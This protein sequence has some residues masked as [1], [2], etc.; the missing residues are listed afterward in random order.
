MGRAANA[1]RFLPAFARARSQEGDEDGGWPMVSINTEVPTCGSKGAAISNHVVRTM[2]EYTGRGPT[3]HA[4]TSTRTPSSS[5]CRTPSPKASTAWWP[6]TRSSRPE[7]AQGLPGHDGPG[8]HRWRRGDP[9]PQG[10]RVHERQPHR[11]RMS[12]WRCSCSHLPASSTAMVPA[13][14]QRRRPKRWPALNS[15]PVAEPSVSGVPRVGCSA[16][17]RQRPVG[18]GRWSRARPERRSRQH[19]R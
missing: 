13:V 9:R 19:G 1:F 4:P 11:S 18:R 2:S 10:R 3:R 16:A 12:P 5:C 17:P 15:A 14:P 6:T 7:D 8:P